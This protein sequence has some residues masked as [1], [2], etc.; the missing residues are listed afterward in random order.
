[1][2]CS[3][4]AMMMMVVFIAINIIVVGGRWFIRNIQKTIHPTMTIRYHCMNVIM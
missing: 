4:V 1:M 3:I 2:V